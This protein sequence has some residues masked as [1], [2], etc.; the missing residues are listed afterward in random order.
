MNNM[1][2]RN[3]LCPCGSGKKYK[4]CCMGKP[5]VKLKGRIQQKTSNDLPVSI[6]PGERGKQLLSRVKK[7]VNDIPYWDR[8]DLLLPMS[9]KDYRQNTGEPSVWKPT[10]EVRFD[11]LPRTP[12]RKDADPNAP[13]ATDR[14]GEDGDLYVTFEEVDY[15]QPLRK[16]KKT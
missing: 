2:G 15:R 9:E 12:N 14:F 5:A 4:K 8:P 11:T 3:D 6:T 13:I 1:S 7:V 10:E 16:G